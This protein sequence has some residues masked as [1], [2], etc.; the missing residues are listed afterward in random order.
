MIVLGVYLCS[1]ASYLFSPSEALMIALCRVAIFAIYSF[2]CD[3]FIALSDDRNYVGTGYRHMDDFSDRILPIR[4]RHQFLC[5]LMMSFLGPLY[6]TPVA[7]NIVLSA[8]I[9]LICQKMGTFLM[10]KNTRLS[11]KLFLFCFF[12]PELLA[13][14]S[15]AFKD[16]CVL[17]A[18]ILSLYSV[19]K[20][21]C[22]EFVL[23][24]L[25]LWGSFWYFQD[26][27]KY[28]PYI[29]I[30]AL[31]LSLL[32]NICKTLKI[33]ALY[34]APFCLFFMYSKLSQGLKNL[35]HF[36]F[37]YWHWYLPRFRPGEICIRTLTMLSESALRP[38]G[39][40]APPQMLILF[41]WYNLVMFLFLPIGIYLLIKNN[42]Q[43]PFAACVIIYSGITLAVMCMGLEVITSGRHH[44]Q[45]F[46]IKVL[47]QFLVFFWLK[48]KGQSFIQGKH[49]L[50]K[51]S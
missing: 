14:S 27:R 32:W 20:F 16:I 6:T 3:H 40:I 21:F 49:L 29:V 2:F 25:F 23:S 18:L 42:V 48:N 38:F 11:R 24:G 39:V 31:G 45:Y 46:F 22:K 1:R 41:V 43:K 26:S 44:M 28:A 47:C 4:C 51:P 9:T 50:A 36:A 17:T 37:G 5:G 12:H 35:S 13:Y 33:K 10:G 34:L 7:F 15:Y 8:V 19:Q 30:A